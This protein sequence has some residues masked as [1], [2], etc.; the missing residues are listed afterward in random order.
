MEN[1]FMVSRKEPKCDKLHDDLTKPQWQSDRYQN[2]QVLQES[3][4]QKFKLADFDCS[5]LKETYDK[6]TYLLFILV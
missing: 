5:R 1:G 4:V 6:E 3:E 2:L